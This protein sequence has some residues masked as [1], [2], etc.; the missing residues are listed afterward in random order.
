M[1]RR[2]TLKIYFFRR[3]FNIRR[4]GLHYLSRQRRRWAVRMSM[5]SFQDSKQGYDK[6]TIITEIFI[7]NLLRSGT[8]KKINISV[9]KPLTK[10]ERMKTEDNG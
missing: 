7:Y 2:M 10:E 9:N 1:K 4:L 3:G 5:T 8:Y 6:L